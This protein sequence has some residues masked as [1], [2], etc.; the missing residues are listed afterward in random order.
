M[1]LG[2][3]LHGEFVVYS[4]LQID[5]IKTPPWKE[6]AEKVPHLGGVL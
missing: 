6:Q 5:P 1:G 3:W 2:E 4:N